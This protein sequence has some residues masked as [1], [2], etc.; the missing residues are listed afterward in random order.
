MKGDK[1]VVIVICDSLRA[2]LIMFSGGAPERDP[3]AFL[4]WVLDGHSYGAA[5]GRGLWTRPS[6]RRAV[7]RAYAL[8]GDARTRAYSRLV[9]EL[10][11]A[12]PYAVYGSFVDA[13]YF[14]PQVRCKTFQRAGGFVDLGALCVPHKR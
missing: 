14:S 3:W 13:A 6:F 8:R 9:R 5:L 7:A 4:S 12:A 1:R 11:E 10:M 2:D